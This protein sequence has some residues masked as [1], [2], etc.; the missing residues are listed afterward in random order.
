MHDTYA[1]LLGPRSGPRAKER[2]ILK[3]PGRYL[4]LASADVGKTLIET[5]EFSFAVH[6]SGGEPAKPDELGSPDVV[7]V[8]AAWEPIDSVKRRV[9]GSWLNYYSRYEP[10]A[11]Q[12]YGLKVFVA[13]EAND[14]SKL[15][16]SDDLR[17]I[18]ECRQTLPDRPMPCHL[19]SNSGSYLT[20]EV[21]FQRSSLSEWHNILTLAA[22]IL[23]DTVKFNGDT[24]G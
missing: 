6:K 15:Y 8:T 12:S 11:E 9:D 13:P 17:T 22:N 20:I 19:M 16:V 7:V 3:M 1:F 21:R 2:L 24:N 4:R 10:T 23:S 5:G 14:L 18:I